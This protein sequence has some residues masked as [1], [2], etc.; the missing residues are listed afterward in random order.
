MSVKIRKQY[1]SKITVDSLPLHDVR[2]VLPLSVLPV[3]V[4]DRGL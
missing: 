3:G 4:M 1:H 2:L